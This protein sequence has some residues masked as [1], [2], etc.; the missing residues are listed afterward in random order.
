M[1]WFYNDEGVAQ[2]PVDE[3]AMM[4]LISA[5]KIL[6]HTLIWH[7]GLELWHEAGTLNPSWWQPVEEKSKPASQ[8][9]NTDK[10]ALRRSPVPLAPTEA[11]KQAKAKSLL[12]RLFGGKE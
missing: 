5:G 8:S 6:V 2:G 1:T 11:P 12:K 9:A 7:N 3:S 10:V 4:T